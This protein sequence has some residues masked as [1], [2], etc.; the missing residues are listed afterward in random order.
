MKRLS[1]F[2]TAC[3]LFIL[4][5]SIALGEYERSD[6]GMVASRSELSSEVGRDILAQGGNAIDAAVAT[7][8]AL[9][10]TYPS[11]GNL[12][13]GGFMVLTL[14]NGESLSLDYREKAP[15]DA[16]RDMFLD[17]AGDVDS[18]LALNS[19]QSAGIPGSVAGLLEALDKYGSLSREQVLA[20]AIRLAE[21]GFILNNDI[22]G[23]FRGQFNNFRNIPA[24]LQTF[25]NA[26]SLY[27]SGDR[28][29]QA[30]LAS[31]LKA[32]S[33][34]GRDGFY[35]GRVADLIVADMQAN[36]GLIT[37]QDLSDYQ[38]VWREPIH[39]T[40]RGFDVWSMPAPSSG[41][42][43]LVQMLNMLEP[44]D[45]VSLGWGTKETVHLMIEAQRRAY[46]DRAEHLGDPDFVD[47]PAQRLI[48]KEYARQR[49]ANFNPDQAGDSATITAG[50]WINESPDTTHYSVMDEFGNAV[51]VTTTLNRSY[52][53][54][55]V[56]PGAGF[57]LNNEMDD[58][59]SKPDTPNSY[60]LIGRVANE[61]QPG[62]RML[63]SMT[64]TIVTKEGKPVLLTGSP[65]GSTIINTVLQVVMNVI[66]H[67]MSVE[68]AV[69]SP[70][71][72]HQWLPN[73]VRYEIGAISDEVAGALQAIG[74]Q[75]LNG[76]RFPIGDANTIFVGE[77]F[78]EGVSDPRN[79]GGVAGF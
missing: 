61:I 74:H 3:L 8:F 41:G 11:A 12:G 18:N 71:I 55:I 29:L 43:L 7:G 16:S 40:Y 34:Q 48:S 10:V 60:G 27:E 44:Y 9:A 63:S 19:H 56:V 5:F 31:T 68:A 75:N 36:N 23:Q 15:A 51:S 45:I 73:T 57:L 77:N 72:H 49:F 66:D 47:V 79:V 17:A 33:D 54:K 70:R 21:E 25:S 39:S 1:T 67:K 6:H 24:S 4:P 76:S 64:P 42:V 65:G 50:S 28:W 52:G 58:F 32:I 30:D 46:A 20:P 37:H 22:A 35:R 13:G 26:G 53:S 59:S 78:V 14:A 62:K 38:P 69:A 2:F